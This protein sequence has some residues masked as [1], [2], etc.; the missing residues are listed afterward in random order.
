K[1]DPGPAIRFGVAWYPQEWPES[2]W[3][4][5]LALM[6][7]AGINTV[8][9]GEFSWGLLEPEEGRYD[10]DWLERVVAAAAAHHIG[11]IL[12]T[13]TDA[14]PAWLT[15]KYPDTLRVAPDG[16]RL[17]FPMARRFSIASM[18]Y[19]AF[20]RDIVSRL[21]ERF[22]HNPDVIGWQIDNEYTEESYDGEAQRG[23]RDWLR[24][25]YGTLDNLNTR[26]MT[27][28][29]TQAYDSW[30]E[31][32]LPPGGGN[33]GLLLD[34][35]RFITSEWRSYQKNQIDVLRPRID[36]RQVLTT[37][38]GGLGWADR[39][40]RARVVADLDLA[41]WDEYIARQVSNPSGPGPRYVAL[42]HLDPYLQG[43]THDLVRGWKR[44]NFWV[45]EAQPGYVDWAPQSFCLD[46]GETRL[47]AWQAVGH[48]ADLFEFW[49][50]R[51]GLDTP[52]QYHG[53]LAGPDGTPVPLYQE[54]RQIGAEFAKAGPA[55]AGTEP[56]SDVAILHD[57]DSRWAIDF[58]PQTTR[59]DQIGVL[60][61]YYRPL[62]D[63]SPSVDI[64]DPRCDLSGYKL[65]LAP[66]LNVISA[67]LAAHLLAYVRGGGHLVLG[68]R[69]GMKDEFN[70][71][72]VE[73]QPGPLVPALGGRV[74]QFYVLS[75]DAPVSG[76]WGRGEATIW[77]ELLSTRAP[78]TRVL[79]RYGRCNGW[80]DGQP[81]AITRKLGRG[82]L[83][84][85]GAL[86]DPALMRSAVR[87]M[88]EDAGVPPPPIAA[89]DGVEVCR[90]VGK[91]RQVFVLLNYGRKPAAVEL[92]WPM[93]DLLDG[94]RTR[95]IVLAPLGVAVLSRAG[96]ASPE[97]DRPRGS[98]PPN[99]L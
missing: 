50:W 32:R 92:P 62:R 34:A 53:V 39:F 28:Y 11:V 36:P 45:L 87:S 42:P 5:D 80:L 33:P 27:R 59:Y 83:T 61:D 31:I 93:R 52:G 40:N 98:P 9:V 13:P 76:V 85:L 91:D 37:N 94:G 65:V 79:L 51:P 6:Q 8:R 58:H 17:S 90:R 54:V 38:L 71:L 72:N 73:R 66:S 20:C 12:G 26:W 74:E 35:K 16:V 21:A 7:K 44:R 19:R 84:Y 41:S 2:Q 64:V 82:T 18:R 67:R 81:A 60:L 55:F 77:A 14:P 69:S 88:L 43:A 96:P 70:A 97:N 30:D 86:L 56:V 49:R 68:P 22:G 78:D 95:R 89:P 63:L 75:G 24:A 1:P 25:K 46:R 99:P 57:Y 10:F 15:Q 4:T 23:F 48:G 3:D 47:M 29:W